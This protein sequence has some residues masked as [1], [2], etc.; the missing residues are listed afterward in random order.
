MIPL[1][2][3]CIYE[4]RD[5]LSDRSPSMKAN[6]FSC[7]GVKSQ[8]SQ[9][10]LM[11]S[12]RPNFF[13]PIT[14]HSIRPYACC[15]ADLI[16]GLACSMG[17]TQ[18]AVGRIEREIRNVEEAI[19]SAEDE[20]GKAVDKGDKDY[21]RQKE[22]QLRQKEVQMR[23]KE[24]QLRGMLLKLKHKQHCCYFFLTRPSL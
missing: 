21:W 4:H 16:I 18:D 13:K 11:Q 8:A 24:A 17:D 15:N 3:K 19:K 7:S 9:P 2:N 20:A 12:A 22:L 1:A 14:V 23:Q 5:S 10:L 6:G